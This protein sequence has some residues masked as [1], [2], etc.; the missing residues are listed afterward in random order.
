MELPAIFQA[1]A[2]FFVS[3]N[4]P[5][6]L[7]GG[8]ARDL[9]RGGAP[10]DLDLAV[11]RRTAYVWRANSPLPGARRLSHLMSNGPPAGLYRATS[12]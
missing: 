4:V 10:I 8:A 9:A 12:G 11:V 5:A 3:R 6:W 7:V 2:A 1:L